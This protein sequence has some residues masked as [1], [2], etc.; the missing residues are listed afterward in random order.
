M[1]TKF[2]KF[3]WI[4]KQLYWDF[5]HKS[6]HVNQMAIEKTTCHPVIIISSTVFVLWKIEE[7]Q[8]FDSGFREVVTLLSQNHKRSNIGGTIYENKKR[9][10]NL[11]LFASRTWIENESVFFKLWTFRGN[12]LSLKIYLHLEVSIYPFF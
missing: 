12:T 8:F 10:I 2:V 7:K 6:A 4:H 3:D 11:W 1:Y 9:M 5:S